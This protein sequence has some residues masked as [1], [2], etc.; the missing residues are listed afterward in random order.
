MRSRQIIELPFAFPLHR[1][2]PPGLAPAAA[3]PASILPGPA[4]YW[5]SPGDE[6]ID[7]L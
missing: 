2:F 4:C 5:I 7:D 1:T 3:C 6:R